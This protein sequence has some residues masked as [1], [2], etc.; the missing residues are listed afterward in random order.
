MSSV[1]PWEEAESE[2]MNWLHRQMAVRAAATEGKVE[3]VELDEILDRREVALTA[4]VGLV[5]PP[6]EWFTDPLLREPTPLT[7]TADGRVYGHAAVWGT[8]H[9]G[10]QN[11]CQEPPHSRSGYRWF[12]LKSRDTA[13]GR[14]VPVGTVTLDTGHAPITASRAATVAHYDNTGTRVA[15]VAAGEDAHGIWVSGALAPGLSPE[16]VTALKAAALSGDW[17][18]VN[19]SMEL[20]GLLAVNVPGFPVPR[21]RMALAASA[22]GEDVPLALVAAGVYCGCE[23]DELETLASEVEKIYLDSRLPALLAAVEM[24]QAERDRRLAGLAAAAEPPS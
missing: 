8:C 17:R 23:G 22:E 18:L 9:T 13:D 20:I 3:D 21:P 6:S 4:A 11:R 14:T 5:D 7:I 2:W 24:E 16:K 19:G 1:E 10:F 12:H 15:D